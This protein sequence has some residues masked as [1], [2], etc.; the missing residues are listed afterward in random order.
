MAFNR[1]ALL[2]NSMPKTVS[3]AVL[4]CL[5]IV[6]A[7]QSAEAR[8]DP[9]TCI[10]VKYFAA[11][12]IRISPDGKRVAYLVKS[13]NLDTNE[14]DYFLY[15]KGLS[16][17]Q[18][19]DHAPVVTLV[20]A[21]QLTW[22]GDGR[23]IAL[24]ARQAGKVAVVFVDAITGEI[25]T[26]ARTTADVREFS[27]DRDG[28][29]IVFATEVPRS[30]DDELPSE[31]DRERGFRIPS[32]NAGESSE[33]ERRI[34]LTKRDRSGA[35]SP[36]AALTLKSP[37]TEKALTILPYTYSLRLSVSPNGRFV[38]VTCLVSDGLPT[39]WKKSRWVEEI[40][41]SSGPLLITVL[42]DLTSGATSMP[43]ATPWAYSIAPVWS[44][45][46]R[47]YFE[48]ASAPPGSETESKDEENGRRGNA[49]LF[50][51]DLDT[52]KAELA[53]AHSGDRVLPLSFAS[54][55]EADIQIDSK[56]VV[57]VVRDRNGWH[58][59]STL[60]LP[61]EKGS[62]CFGL[63][64]DGDTFVGSFESPTQAPRLL[65]FR[66]GE[67]AVTPIVD[68]NPQLKRMPMAAAEEIRWRTSAGIEI[69]G[70]LFKPA[71]YDP[72]RRYPLVIQT[73]PN[74]G[75]YVCD[76]GDVHFPSFCPQPL[77]SAGILY[78]LR[79]EVD[80]ERRM[81]DQ[82]KY[83]KGYPGG[84][85]EAAFYMD[86]WDS[87]VDTLSREGIVDRSKVGIIGFSRTGWYTEFA[88]ARGTVHY[89]AATLAD[90]VQYSLAEYW[91]L[92]SESYMRGAEAMYGGP[93]YGKGLANWEKYSV[94][95]TLENINTPTL[96]ETMGHG[97]QHLNWQAPPIYLSAV[98]DVFAGLNRLGKPVEWYYYPDEGHTPDHP[99][100]RL[101]SV[102]R[103]VDWY[104][105]WLTGYED[106]NP[107]KTEQ[108]K[109]WRAMRELCKRGR[110]E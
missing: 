3:L 11:D 13:A 107:A 53:T 52:K 84:L 100:A 9:A 74:Y 85:G 22:I 69:T 38:L 18:I 19:A 68:I 5:L 67:T 2:G 43:L 6:C 89:A 46:S 10:G 75:A 21:S 61:L 72:H 16:E 76:A 87:A 86:V 57:T 109:R 54:T 64:A 103:N 30:S 82:P 40:V 34:F 31:R 79:T 33:L 99:L 94:S 27:V 58:D 98:M 17:H 66:R 44:P 93:P 48:S 55:D 51:V 81:D 97:V 37:F 91:L 45:D 88:L 59:A 73:Q 25:K 92:R 63:T 62:H 28:D 102:T 1:L 106:P 24:L 56:T 39:E 42:H 60:R 104:R 14:N 36:P 70:L 80:N 95:F 108:Y 20:D 4:G 12:S 50:W 65:L 96:L 26:V 8:V 49:H 105:F 78:L 7:F 47:A 32:Q 35:W 90:N 41:N 29:T 23:W 83:P 77:A 110:G 15:V 101:A 71:S